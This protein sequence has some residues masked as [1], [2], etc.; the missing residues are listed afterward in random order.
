MSEHGDLARIALLLTTVVFLWDGAASPREIYQLGGHGHSWGDH[1]TLSFV[2]PH[3]DPGAIQPFQTELSHN[4]VPDLTERGGTIGTTT[5]TEAIPTDWNTARMDM[6]DGD[7]STAFVHE[8]QINIYGGAGRYYTLDMRFDLGAPFPVERLR[9]RTRPDHPNNLVRIYNLWINDGSEE[10]QT[11][12]GDPV[13]T[14]LKDEPDNLDPVADIE[15]EPRIIQHI[16]LRPWEADVTWE[17]AELEAY[18]QGYVPNAAFESVP[19]DLGGSASLGRIWWAGRHDPA[20]KIT[21]QTRTG[22]DDQPEV[23]WRKTGIGDQQVSTDEQGQP[24]TR[25]AYEQ[26]SPVKQGAITADLE[27]WSVWHTYE[28]AAGLTGTQILSP[29]PR[30]YVQTRISFSSDGMQGGRI[31]S[32]WFQYSRPPLART[33]VGEI[34]PLEVAAG[35]SVRFTYYLR[36]GLDGGQRGFDTLELRTPA[37]LERVHAVRIEGETVAFRTEPLSGDPPGIV[38]YIP[39]VATDQARVEIDLSARVFRY[40]TV[41]SAAAGDSENDEVPVQ[42][43]AGNVADDVLSDDL[44]VRTTLD[45]NLLSDVTAAPNPFS[46]N[47]DGVN[48]EVELRFDV[49]RLTEDVPISVAVYDLAGR[50]VRLLG[51]GKGSSSGYEVSWDGLDEQG[52]PLPP[53]IYVYLVKVHTG[54]EVIERVG[55]IALA[56]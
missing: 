6:A 35:E 32:L 3:R 40:G 7:S 53:G 49:L 54:E 51:N 46:P 22:W 56:Y 14:L 43:S 5:A 12:F 48:D 4:L 11:E 27:N 42:V 2:D 19:I 52:S 39:R 23:Y 13:W 37:E 36:L 31:D 1:G 20:A 15:F 21:I 17:I 9:L 10:T 16:R 38:L 24:L 25:S 44:R 8:P 55:H 33:V 18:G 28:F 26:L 50:R 29:S 34:A 45:S 47:A 41:F 30:R